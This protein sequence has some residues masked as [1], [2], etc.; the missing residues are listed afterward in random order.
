MTL[1]FALF[2]LLYLVYIAVVFMGMG[3]AVKYAYEFNLERLIPPAITMTTLLLVLIVLIGLPPLLVSLDYGWIKGWQRRLLQTG[4]AAPA[5][6]LR[7][8]DSGV[9]LG[10]PDLSF[11]VR[12]RLRVQPDGE[13]DFDATVEMPVSRVAIP[14]VGECLHVRFDPCD[15]RRVVLERIQL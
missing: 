1:K 8:E 14:R 10:N 5:Q 6:I 2:T 15:H 7:V 4:R 11:I 13:T 3:F 12:L 9:S